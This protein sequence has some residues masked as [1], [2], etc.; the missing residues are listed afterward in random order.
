MNNIRHP[1]KCLQGQLLCISWQAN[2]QFTVSLCRAAPTAVPLAQRIFRAA[3]SSPARPDSR[4]QVA[5]VP[6]R[7]NWFTLLISR[8]IWRQNRTAW[9]FRAG[10]GRSK[11]VDVA[12]LA[13]GGGGGG[14]DQKRGGSHIHVT[15]IKSPSRD[16]KTRW[17]R[18]WL[19]SGSFD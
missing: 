11:G 5:T 13:R 4:E 2:W 6:E 18:C 16:S 7:I 17:S 10:P 1:R 9:G 15:L 8:T 12:F 14:L 3:V 19:G